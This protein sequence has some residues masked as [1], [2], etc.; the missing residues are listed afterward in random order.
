MHADMSASPAGSFCGTQTSHRISPRL[1]WNSDTHSSA[2]KRSRCAAATTRSRSIATNVIRS[3]THGSTIASPGS[4]SSWLITALTETDTPG[5][6]A[7]TCALTRFVTCS[8]SLR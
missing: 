1:R 7:P 4:R 3:R 5:S 8:R 6:T 2:A